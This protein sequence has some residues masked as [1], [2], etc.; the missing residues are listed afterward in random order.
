EPEAKVALAPPPPATAVPPL[1]LFRLRAVIEQV[2]DWVARGEAREGAEGGGVSEVPLAAVAAA[3]AA[4]PVPQEGAAP[5]LAPHRGE[6]ILMAM[7]ALGDAGVA[8]A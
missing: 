7:A 3:G 2:E 4:V 1:L 5:E 6:M 8:K